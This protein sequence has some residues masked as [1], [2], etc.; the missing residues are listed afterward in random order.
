M[1]KFIIPADPFYKKVF[2]IVKT[3]TD[4]YVCPQWHV[5]PHGTTREQIEIDM[6]LILIE[7]E[8]PLKRTDDKLYE[9]IVKGSKPGKEYVVKFN[10]GSW[11][12][13]CPAANFKR[14]DCKHIKIQQKVIIQ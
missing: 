14:G 1:E 4:T 9:T 12:C 3:P 11:S 7:A 10:K 13:T 6:S 8:A 2:V 5:V